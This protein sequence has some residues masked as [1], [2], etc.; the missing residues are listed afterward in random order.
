MSETN[1]LSKLTEK[2]NTG[3]KNLRSMARR[4]KNLRNKYNPFRIK[5]NRTYRSSK[6]FIQKPFKSKQKKQ[7]LRTLF[8]SKSPESGKCNKKTTK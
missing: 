5:S 8:S 7:R 6:N 3:D 2:L 1:K 4:F